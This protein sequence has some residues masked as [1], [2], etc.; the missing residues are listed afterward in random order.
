MFLFETDCI[1]TMDTFNMSQYQ[2]A[3]NYCRNPRDSAF[4]RTLSKNITS[5]P[6]IP[7]P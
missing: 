7:H 1:N 2:D 3:F 4:H 5:K 6:H